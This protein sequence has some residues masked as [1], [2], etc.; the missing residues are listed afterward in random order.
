M[1]FGDSIKVG[2]SCLAIVAAMAFAQNDDEKVRE[3]D[4]ELSQT[5]IVLPACTDIE[6]TA[7]DVEV[8]ECAP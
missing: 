3:Q 7:K 4:E 5:V 1:K 2:A 6:T 8:R